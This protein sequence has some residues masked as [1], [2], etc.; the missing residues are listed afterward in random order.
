[1]PAEKFTTSIIVKETRATSSGR[2][3]AGAEYTLYQVIATKPSGEPIN[4]NLRA[5]EDL[6]KN[7]VIEVDAEL[8]R[9]QRYGDS[10]TLQRKGAGGGDGGGDRMS[11]LEERVKR[12]ED[13]LSGRGE[14]GG[15]AAQPEQAP[16]QAPPQ[17]PP[18]PPPVQP[19]PPRDFDF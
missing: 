3:G 15:S 13:F 7:V 17:P 2:T 1:M 6:P 16:T 12:I 18:P 11:S 5:F 9:S 19:D 4:L 8:Y 14:F 10:Y